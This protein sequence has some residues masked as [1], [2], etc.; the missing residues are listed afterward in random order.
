M[1]QFRN[2][3]TSEQ[4]VEIQQSF[5]LYWSKKY[6]WMKNLKIKERVRFSLNIDFSFEYEK[7]VFSIS[8]KF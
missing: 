3:R 7:F 1:F 8:V 2:D 6:L 5:C 4:S